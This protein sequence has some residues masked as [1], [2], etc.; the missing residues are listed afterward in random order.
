[1]LNRTHDHRS[2]PGIVG[3][4]CVRFKASVP[5]RRPPYTLPR[6]GDHQAHWDVQPFLRNRIT[7]LQKILGDEIEVYHQVGVKL[8]SG[9]L[10]ALEPITISVLTNF[11]S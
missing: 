7:V 2:A 5:R 4:V 8:S 6:W 10:K 9:A 3:F 11:P 1:M